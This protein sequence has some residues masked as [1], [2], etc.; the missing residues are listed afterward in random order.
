MTCLV[1]T[2][3]LTFPACLIIIVRSLRRKGEGPPWI[4]KI[5]A[6]KDC[7]LS[8]EWEKTRFTTFGPRRKFFGKIH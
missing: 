7:F 4:L 5:L 1:T 2:V 8:F 6:E 3:K